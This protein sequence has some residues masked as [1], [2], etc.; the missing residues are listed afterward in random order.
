MASVNPVSLRTEL[1]ALKGQFET[2]CARGNVSAEIRTLFQALLTLLDLLMA[3]FLEKSTPK[4]SVSTPFDG[5]R[6]D[7]FRIV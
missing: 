3:V 2:L 4:M 7:F 1:A 6:G 5:A